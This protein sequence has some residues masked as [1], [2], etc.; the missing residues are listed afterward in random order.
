[1]H[2]HLAL[3]VAQDLPHVVIE[4]KHISRDIELRDSNFEEILFVYR[5]DGRR[6]Y[7]V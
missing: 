4:A 6:R 5:Y 2:G 1:M 3:A 7:S